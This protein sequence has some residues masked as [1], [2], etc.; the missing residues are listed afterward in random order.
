MNT[1]PSLSCKID[2]MSDTS[3]PEAFGRVDND[4]KVFVKT[5]DGERE[6]GQ[7]PGADPEKALAFFVKRFRSL[8]T[9]VQL[10]E[11]RVKSGTLA[12]DAQKSVSA[13]R[14]NVVAANAVGDL[15]GLI[16]RLDALVPIIEENAQERKQQ[17]LQQNEETKELKEKMI[18]DA[19]KIADSGDWR[20][21]M[22]KFQ[23]LVDK[24]KKLPRIDRKTDDELWARFSASRSK[25]TKGRKAYQSQQNERRDR[26]RVIKLGIIEEAKKIADSTDW[27][28]TAGEFRDLM[29]RWKAAGSARREDEEKLWSEFRGLQD[30]FFDARTAA[31]AAQDEEY[32]GNQKAKEKLL[33]EYE[34]K[35]LPV[36][37]I[38]AAKAAFAEFLEKYN[39]IGRVPRDAMRPLDRRVNAI[40]QAI[41]QVE[42]AEWKRTDPE[43]RQ[44]AEDTVAT[45]TEQIQKLTRQAEE[46]EAKGDKKAAKLRDQIAIYSSWLEQAQKTL[47]EFSA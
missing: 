19:E 47:D 35:I 1:K 23:S 32:E 7:I 22:S 38:K 31:F 46:A 13:A 15:N 44:R 42:E 41:K 24:W 36:K 34:A 17:R 14:A 33:D 27:G 37:E 43:A 45:F 40:E 9:E 21:G 20:R 30:K 8:E 5:T 18:A 4:G 25:Y 3:R 29:S 39:E 16:A 10:L 6:V 2:V 28:P 12:R 11:Q 26:A